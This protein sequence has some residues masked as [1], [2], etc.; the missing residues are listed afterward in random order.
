MKD[1]V[2]Y[3]TIAAFVC[4]APVCAQTVKDAPLAALL[5]AGRYAEA[6]RVATARIVWFRS[7][8]IPFQARNLQTLGTVLVTFALLFIWWLTFSRS[9]WKLRLSVA[10]GAEGVAAVLMCFVS[11]GEP[12]GDGKCISQPAPAASVH[13]ACRLDLPDTPH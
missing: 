9:R 4:S 7:K 1:A 8:N 5:D 3:A 11:E 13:R 12:A 6:E 2:R 10:G